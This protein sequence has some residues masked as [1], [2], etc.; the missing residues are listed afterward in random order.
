MVDLE[1]EEGPRKE[2]RKRRRDIDHLAFILTAAAPQPQRTKV[3][4]HFSIMRMRGAAGHK[5]AATS[6]ARFR[7]RNVTVKSLFAISF[8]CLPVSFRISSNDGCSL[9]F[10]YVT[11]RPQWRRGGS[12]AVS[13][14][15]RKS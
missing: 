1:E 4:L 5:S 6:L 10:R 12:Q 13:R 7:R 2:G 8:D 9:S 15:Y 3:L 14:K 11:S